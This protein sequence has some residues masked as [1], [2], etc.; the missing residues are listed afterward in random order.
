[1]AKVVVLARKHG[2]SY[3][4]WAHRVACR[5]V[6]EWLED[7]YQSGIQTLASRIKL[8]RII[9]SIRKVVGR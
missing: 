2:K 1:M 6:L 7:V 4:N 8:G 3:Q 5:V 9:S